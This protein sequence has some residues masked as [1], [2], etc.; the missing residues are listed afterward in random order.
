M[1]KHNAQPVADIRYSAQKGVRIRFQHV[2]IYSVG[3]PM[4]A[5]GTGWMPSVDLYETRDDVVLEIN[6]AGIPADQVHVQFSATTVR[7]SG[8][9]DGRPAAA[10]RCYHILE[11][12]R[13]VFARELDLPVPVDPHTVDATFNHGLLVVRAAKQMGGQAHGCSS[14]TMEGW[15]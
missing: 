3:R 12:E 1:G 10:V 2:Q 6:L 15:E 14:G 11:I 7:I 4:L 9:R 13:G 8:S 5:S